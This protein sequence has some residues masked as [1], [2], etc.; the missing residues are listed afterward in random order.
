MRVLGQVALPAKPVLHGIPELVDGYVGT[1][2]HLTVGNRER[3]VEDAGVGEVAHGETVEPF[4]RAGKSAAVRFI[5][6]ANLSGE[7][8]FILI[9]GVG[10]ERKAVLR[11]ADSRG[12]LSPHTAQVATVAST[13]WP[14]RRADAHATSGR[15][16][17]HLETRRMHL[18]L[19]IALSGV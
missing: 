7:H 16:S 14:R 10:E 17:S 15:G 8:R 5:L 11:T 2:L 6:N 9:T 1:N 4:Q 18:R 3:V 13:V 19:Q 12:R